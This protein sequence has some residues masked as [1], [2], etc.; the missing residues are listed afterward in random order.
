[1]VEN[2]GYFQKRLRHKIFALKL[3]LL[4]FG[5]VTLF[6]G[7]YP[8]L[9]EGGVLG[10]FPFLAVEGMGYRVAII[11]VGVLALLAW[12]RSKRT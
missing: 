4:L 1:M 8:F 11:V 9:V 12:F 10:E 6:L 3:E 7:A 2:D 5:L